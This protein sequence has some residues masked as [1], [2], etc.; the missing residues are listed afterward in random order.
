MIIKKITNPKIRETPFILTPIPFQ[1][2]LLSSWLVRTAYAHHTHPHTFMKLHLGLCNQSVSINNFDAIIS[3]DHIK[4]LLYKTHQQVDIFRMSLQSYN[5]YLQ[6]SIITNGLNKFLCNLRFCPICLREDKIIYFRKNWKV[7]FNTICIKHK[8][9]LLDSCPQCDRLISITKMYKNKLSVKYC[10]NCGFDL[11]KS[12]KIPIPKNT[13][14]ISVLKLNSVLEQGYILFKS[15]LIY[16]FVFFDTIVQLSKIIL[17][18]QKKLNLSI[19]LNKV[20]KSSNSYKPIYFQV[21]IKKQHLLF[22][23]V[24][25]L[26]ESYP[27]RFKQYIKKNKLSHWKITKDMKYISFWFEELINNLSP[28]MIHNSNIITKIEIFNGKKYLRSKN[29]LINKASLS[30]LFKCNFFSSYNNLSSNI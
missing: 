26:F 30:R 25:S 5:G 28:R 1:D 19:D 27:Y 16:S 29:I 17:R 18:Y 22:N 2:E 7:V 10:Y 8:C 4:L 11:S 20:I 15:K 3:E 21:S 12:R 23:T 13:R 24:M 6:E 9:F 14:L